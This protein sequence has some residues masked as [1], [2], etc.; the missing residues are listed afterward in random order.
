MRRLLTLLVLIFALPVLAATPAVTEGDTQT[1]LGPI[2]VVGELYRWVGSVLGK[3]VQATVAPITLYV[4]T[5]GSDSNDCLSVSTACLTIQAALD[6]IPKVINH[7]VTVTVG[8]GNFAGFMVSGFQEATYPNQLIIQGTIG[9]FVPA[10]GWQSGTADGAGGSTEKL[11]DTGAGWT[12]NNLRGA[13]LFIGTEYRTIRDNT[14]DTI[15]VVGAFTATCNGKAYSIV[16]QKT[17]INADAPR[18]GTRI[19]MNGS[20][21]RGDGIL[22]RDFKT[23]GGTNAVWQHN[24]SGTRLERIYAKDYTSFGITLQL[25][26]SASVY[27]LTATTSV[28]STGYAIFLSDALIGVIYRLFVF[29]AANVYGIRMYNVIP[30]F[31]KE[32]VVYDVTNSTCYGISIDMCGLFELTG[33]NIVKRIVGSSGAV[34][35]ALY[36]GSYAKVTGSL[37]ID[38]VTKTGAVD[39]T[40]GHGIYIVGP[41][42]ANLH[43]VTVTNCT[44]HGIFAIRK[45]GVMLITASIT[46][47]SGYG[48]DARQLASFLIRNGTQTVASNSLGGIRG[49]LGAQILVDNTDGSNTGYGIIAESG[50]RV[51]I[52]TA[53]G[54]TG[55]SG[56]ILIDASPV[57]YATDFSSNYDVVIGGAHSVVQRYDGLDYASVP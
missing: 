5:T 12:A 20:Y 19:Y 57:E 21:T 51:T 38:T 53:T 56:D 1:F 2:K 31:M 47:N 16:E 28:T 15:E 3:S 11:V 39:L 36:T 23:S 43:N 22:I 50:A 30:N 35:F 52:D 46:S 17:V 41:I 32:L 29:S 14:A 40:T 27:D 45:A 42:E 48:I 9:A 4:E 55:S 24:T 6:R 37:T 10:T 34:G 8:I 18:A 25:V 7:A 26:E 13:L 49:S 44:G 33:T 54:V